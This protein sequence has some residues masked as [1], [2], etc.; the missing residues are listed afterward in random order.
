[1]RIHRGQQPSHLAALRYR[2][3]RNAL[4]FIS[5]THLELPPRPP[6]GAGTLVLFAHFDP[7]GIV[8]PYV[9]YYLK[10]LHSLGAAILFVSGSPTLTPESVAPIRPLCAG[11]YTRHTLS[12]DFGSWHLGWC[13]LQQHGWSLDQFDRFAVAN[14]SVYGPLFPIE[15]MWSSFR[16]ADMYGAIESLE[17]APHLQS[18]F[19][20]W[21]LNSRTRPMLNDFWRR[22]QYIVDK[23]KLI[24]RY[25]L[26]LSERARRAGLTIKPFV[27]AAAIQAAYG[28]SPEHQWVSRFS[29]P[30]A[31]N[32][33][34][35]WDGLIE[36]LRFPFLKTILPRSNEPWHDSMPHLRDFIERHTDY[37]YAL[38][39]SNVGRL[40]CGPS[41]W[42]KPATENTQ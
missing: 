38:I 42:T 8:D 14:D 28:R 32:T 31:N 7:Q 26:G 4:R 21:D 41:S 6:A 1:M 11:I 30:P 29:G 35:F 19:L 16:G 18:F 13:I 39:E 40:G 25:E 9:V 23:Y 5:E 17:Q 20:A 2:L 33:L 37:P 36:H 27:S 3:R 10:A 34:Y 22:F 12:L 15:E 24:Q